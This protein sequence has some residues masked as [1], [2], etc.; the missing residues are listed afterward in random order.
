[1]L[2]SLVYRLDEDE[3]SQSRHVTYNNNISKTNYVN[4]GYY[5]FIYLC[6]LRCTHICIRP[7]FLHLS[8]LLNYRRQGSLLV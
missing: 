4:V 5:L 6:W 7:A 8:E 2:E 1:M 3:N